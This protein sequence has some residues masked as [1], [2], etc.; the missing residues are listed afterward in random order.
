MFE[1]NN[2]ILVIGTLIFRFSKRTPSPVSSDGKLVFLQKMVRV[3]SSALKSTFNFL[4]WS[5]LESYQVRLFILRY[6]T[7]CIKKL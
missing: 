4:Q 6:Q 3:P 1:G 5:D 2:G 7:P